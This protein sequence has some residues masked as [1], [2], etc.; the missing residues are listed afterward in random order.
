M[1]AEVAHRGKEIWR[2]DLQI[3]E[4]IWQRRAGHATVVP[5]LIMPL[6]AIP[7]LMNM[8]PCCFFYYILL[9]TQNHCP[10]NNK[11]PGT[12]FV[13]TLALYFVKSRF[14]VGNDRFMERGSVTALGVSTTFSINHHAGKVLISGCLRTVS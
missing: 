1:S 3:I 10:A 14:C 11:V 12:Y 2:A 7:L 13:R 9:I 5:L 8:L 6:F 4:K